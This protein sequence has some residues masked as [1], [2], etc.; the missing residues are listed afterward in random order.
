MKVG[1]SSIR[2]L[3][4]YQQSGVNIESFHWNRDKLCFY[5]SH[6]H[7]N[8]NKLPEPM[9][10]YLGSCTCNWNVNSCIRILHVYGLMSAVIPWQNPK[11]TSN[12][13]KNSYCIIVKLH[14]YSI[15]ICSCMKDSWPIMQKS[16]YI[17][18][19]LSKFQAQWHFIVYLSI[20]F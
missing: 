12:Y 1:S 16:Y 19:K 18:V 8:E 3:R 13:V 15:H 7:Q 11:P 5:L 17:F 10:S 4:Y 6:P 9:K 14:V 2:C 20:K